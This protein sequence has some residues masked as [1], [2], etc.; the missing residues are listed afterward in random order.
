MIDTFKGDG[1]EKKPEWT[2]A[3]LIDDLFLQLCTT[4]SRVIDNSNGWNRE[5]KVSKYYIQAWEL[6]P[7][8]SAG[9]PPPYFIINLSNIRP[10]LVHEIKHNPDRD[11]VISQ[12]IG[13]IFEN[14]SPRQYHLSVAHRLRWKMEP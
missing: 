7:L 4:I 5:I 14:I 12:A 10:D 13:R 6:L 1:H 2:T 11:F 9:D 8:I 3:G